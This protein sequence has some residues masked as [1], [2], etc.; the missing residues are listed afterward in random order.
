MNHQI[1]FL[2][3]LSAAKDDIFREVLWSSPFMIPNQPCKPG[4]SHF[5]SANFQI[6]AWLAIRAPGYSLLPCQAG[7]PRPL[8]GSLV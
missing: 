7:T 4:V 8:I 5:F 3:I 2:V 6:F 1:P